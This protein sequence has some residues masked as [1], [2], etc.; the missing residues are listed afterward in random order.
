MNIRLA[1]PQDARHFIE[2][3][4]AMAFETEGKTLDDAIVGPAVNAIADDPNKGFYVV[5]E[6]EG[7][8]VG[9]LLIT[10]EWSDWRNAWW[11]WIQ[12]VYIRPEA[13]GRKI[14]SLLYD[15]VK[16]R[17]KEAGNVYGI[18]LYVEYENE[19]ATRVYE[20][21]GMERAHYHMYAEQL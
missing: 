16:R 1:A 5:A 8:I 2:F 17:A 21:L 10:Y 9:G 6:D 14:Y 3:N 4:K 19:H 7:Q 15:D 12:S 18:R 11:W 13:R 20:K